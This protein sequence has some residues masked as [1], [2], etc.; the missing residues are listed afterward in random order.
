MNFPV[1]V[2]M[3]VV[4]PYEKIDKLMFF[5]GVEGNLHFLSERS[6]AQRQVE[7]GFSALGG[8]AI[9]MFEFGIRYSRLA[10]INYV[11]VQVGIRFN[12]FE[13]Q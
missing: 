5:A 9:K 2:G 10:R 13:L 12:Q 4:F 6:L 1:G 8:V 11:G 3:Q 7:T